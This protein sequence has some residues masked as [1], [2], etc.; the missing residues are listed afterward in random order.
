[1][2]NVHIEPIFSII[3]KIFNISTRHWI[4]VKRV[5]KKYYFMD[6]KKQYFTKNKEE[7]QTMLQNLL[8]ESTDEL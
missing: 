2:V 3:H 1:L 7:M 4:A 8:N 5:G 6:S